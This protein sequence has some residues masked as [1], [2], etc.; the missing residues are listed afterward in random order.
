MNNQIEV[1]EE[2]FIIQRNNYYFKGEINEESIEKFILSYPMVNEPLDF[3]ISTPGGYISEYVILLHVLDKLEDVTIYPIGDCSS[4]GFYLL[5]NSKHKVCFL[6]ETLNCTV[7]FPR[8]GVELDYNQK[9]TSRFDEKN[10]KKKAKES[11]FFK[12]LIDLNIPTKKRKLLLSGKDIELEIDELK[13]ILDG[14]LT[15]N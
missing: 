5:I 10:F 15:S 2:D 13:I 8:V 9:I 14:K 11:K 1:I 4:C 7:H 3:Y 6:D 12:Q